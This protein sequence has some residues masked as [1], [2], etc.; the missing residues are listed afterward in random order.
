MLKWKIINILLLALGVLV[1]YNAYNVLAGF[2]DGLRGTAVI[3]RLGFKIPL[4]DQ[5]LLGYGLSF[6]I[7]GILFLLAP[8]LINRMRLGKSIGEKS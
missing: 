3:Y 6:A 8:I 2:F 7:I 1:L 4:N 5:S